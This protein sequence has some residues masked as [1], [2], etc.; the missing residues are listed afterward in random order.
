MQQQRRQIRHD[1]HH[2]LGT[3]MVLASLLSRAPDVGAESRERAGRI[4]DEAAWLDQLQRAYED[5]EPDLDSAA[6]GEPAEPVRVDLVAAEVVAAMRL[7]TSIKI[8]FKAHSVW[9]RADRLAFWRA[10]RNLVDNA[11][12]AAAGAGGG[13][14]IR[15]VARD[16][17]AVVL[18]D[19]DAPGLHEAAPGPSSLGLDIV[20]DMAAG[21]GGQLLIRLGE[22][23]GCSVRLSLPAVPPPDTATGSEVVR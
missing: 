10:V 11:V 2:E 13:V 8:K 18:V 9:A 17:W 15:V 22:N 1:I 7:S 16:G 21:W 12:R 3:I 23:G 19:N 6:P 4:L 20:R 5:S 14:D